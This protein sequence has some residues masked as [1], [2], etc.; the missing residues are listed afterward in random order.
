M[1]TENEEV[2]KDVDGNELSE[3]CIEELTNGKGEDDE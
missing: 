2:I 1:G 3:E